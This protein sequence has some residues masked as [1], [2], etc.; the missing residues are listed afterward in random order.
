MIWPRGQLAG[1]GQILVA[2]IVTVA[3]FGVAVMDAGDSGADEG[4]C[5]VAG[6][7]VEEETGGLRPCRGQED[8]QVTSPS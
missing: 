4:V 2:V 1:E 3:P 7:P 6:C 5:A 8:V